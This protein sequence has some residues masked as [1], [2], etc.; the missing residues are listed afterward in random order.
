MNE[1]AKNLTKNNPEMRRR[2][3]AV[4][5]GLNSLVPR[6]VQ[7]FQ[8]LL[9]GRLFPTVMTEKADV[10]K[11]LEGIFPVCAGKEMIR[12]GP[13]GDGGYLVPD[14]VAG[15]DALFSPG[16]SFISGFEKDCAERGMEVF[17]ADRSV[18]KPAEEH[19]KFHFIKKYIG[20][21]TNEDFIT[22]DEWVAGSYANQTSDLMLQMDIE[23]YE[24]ETILNMSDRL[25]RRLRIIVAE[26]HA[27]DQLWNRA[28]FGFVRS[29]FGKLL[30]THRVVHIHPNNRLPLFRKKGLTIPPLLELT[31]V[32]KDRLPSELVYAKD[33]PHP[34]DSD[35]TDWPPV[36]FPKSLL[37]K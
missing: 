35:N 15:I 12:L 29:V 34:L 6:P 28:Y 5:R 27:F 10:E 7:N 37:G 2:L 25:L 30:Q 14:D 1:L 21:T 4:K 8:G 16:V 33:F 31:F 13:Q 26:F 32:R 9:C 24:Y 36:S 19:A 18:D 23:G 17:L 20:A 22:I 11:F 3:K